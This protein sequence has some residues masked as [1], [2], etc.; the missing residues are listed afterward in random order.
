M[1][2]YNSDE[3]EM[4]SKGVEREKTA[5]VVATPEGL[6]CRCMH[7][8]QTHNTLHNSRSRFIAAHIL[9]QVAIRENAA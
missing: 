3:G 2:R 8:T 5:L 1:T 9:T 7:T 4:V 6:M